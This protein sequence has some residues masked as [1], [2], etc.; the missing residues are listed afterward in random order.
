[1]KRLLASAALLAIALLAAALGTVLVAGCGSDASGGIAPRPQAPVRPELASPESA[2]RSYLDWTN[3]A[4]RMA[5]SEF[6][7]L[8][9]TPTWSVHVDSYIQLN[10]QDYKRGI[11]QR[12][13]RFDKRSES[14]EGTQAVL[15]TYEEWDYRYFALADETYTSPAY[16]ASY[17]ATYT[18]VSEGGRWLVDDVA[19]SPLTPLK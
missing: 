19:A 16:T 4:Y 9:C 1:M 3:Y 15:V 7:T 14:V 10:R 11:E 13:T 6:A 18:L 5:N 2:V 17:D 12:L 8:T